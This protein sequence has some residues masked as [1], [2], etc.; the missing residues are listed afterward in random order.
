MELYYAPMEGIN[1]YLH[2]NVSRAV[3][4]DIDKYMTPLI[5]A[6]QKGKLSTK[7]K[8]DILPDHNKECMIPQILTNQ[9]DCFLAVERHYGKWIYGN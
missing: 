8:N 3:F 1:G 4:P 6:N 5:A 2:R 9:A 7:E